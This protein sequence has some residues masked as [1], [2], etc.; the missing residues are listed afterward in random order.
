MEEDERIIVIEPNYL[1]KLVELLDRTPP[2]VIGI[3]KSKANS[4]VELLN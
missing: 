1:Q 4:Q 3:H 2:R